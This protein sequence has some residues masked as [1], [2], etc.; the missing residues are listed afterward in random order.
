MR[1]AVLVVDRQKFAVADPESASLHHVSVDELLRWDRPE[2]RLSRP[3]DADAC[4]VPT[5]ARRVGPAL[6]GDEPLVV[7]EP[8]ALQLDGFRVL[9]WDREQASYVQLDRVHLEV[10]E[11]LRRPTRAM[12]LLGEPTGADLIAACAELVVLDLLRPARDDELAEQSP[13]PEPAVATSDEV[14][15]GPDAAPDPVDVGVELQV[16]R[17]GVDSEDPPPVAR[18][19]VVP[20][21]PA[22][23]RRE[24]MR[25]ALE[26]VASA[27]RGRARRTAQD[28]AHTAVPEAESQRSDVEEA[29]AGPTTT[30]PIEHDPRVPVIPL[31]HFA[32]IVPVG[33]SE[34]IDPCLSIGSL[35]AFAR[36]V[37]GGRLEDVYD[38]HKV[39]PHPDVVFD[40]WAR[41]PRPAVF[42]FS[43]YIWNVERHLELSRRVKELSP[44]SLV[45]HGGPSCPKYDAD[46][47]RF[48]EQHPY[49]DIA[50]RGEGEHTF[51]ELLDRLDGELGPAAIARLSTVEGITYR[52][53]GDGELVRTPDRARSADLD[54]FPSPYLTGELDELVSVPWHSA[55][56]ETNRGCPYGCTFC[57]WGSATMSRIRKFDMARVEA[58]LDWIAQHAPTVTLL[59]CDAN[60]GILERDV[61]IVRRIVELKEQHPHLSLLIFAGLAKNTTKYTQQIFDLMVG[62]GIATM[63]ASLAIQTT[64]PHVLEIANRKNIRLD[65]YDELASAFQAHRLPVMTDI[66]FGMPGSTPDTFAADL[67]HC[68]D[69]G[70]TA[71]MFP[72]LML[73]NSPMNEPGYRAEHRIEVDERGLVVGST[74][75]DASDYATMERLRLLF[76]ASDHLGVLRHLLRYLQWDL[77]IPAME[78]IKEIDRVVLERGDRF[79]LLAFY[80]R[81]F[82]LYTVPP[83]DWVPFYDEVLTVLEERFGVRRSP[84]LDVVLE[85]QLALMPSH[86]RAFPAKVRLEHDVFAWTEHHLDPELATAPLSSFGPVEFDVTD[87]SD[88]CGTRIQRNDFLVRREMESGNLFW[89][90]LDWELASPAARPSFS[91]LHLFAEAGA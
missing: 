23:S 18:D 22:P 60:F 70:I 81:L 5:V 48:M 37:D 34:M 24:W 27:L 73:P 68:F 63:A 7:F 61:E 50:A 58:E 49:V 79:P 16:G 46:T 55:S 82:D 1:T 83:V 64:D 69:R 15:V 35:F 78:V 71:R 86:G 57:D 20:G 29:A 11:L 88:V 80:S 45:V 21:A 76:R 43:D 87:P 28:V 6:D 4:P 31:Y 59:V 85:L 47:V 65:R 3:D 40:E 2:L 42:V 51:A 52:R 41:R 38:F 84:E 75:F 44:E 67:Q 56:I 32:Q 90:G 8:F 30:S 14:E 36:Q 72:L 89:I 91:N 62:A 66:L 39:R 10:L 19:E 26:R 77:G 9:A 17:A 12:E 25:P 74:S 33:H 13:E 53:P 54:E